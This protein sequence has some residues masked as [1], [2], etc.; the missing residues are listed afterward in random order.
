MTV[1]PEL[2]PRKDRKRMGSQ[3]DKKRI[4]KDRKE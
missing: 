3:I 2:P 1:I 4:E